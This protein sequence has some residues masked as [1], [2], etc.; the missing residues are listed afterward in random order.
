[1]EV[2]WCSRL[3][4][5]LAVWNPDGD[6][7]ERPLGPILVVSRRRS[8]MRC[9]AMQ[10]AIPVS[11]P[12]RTT[13]PAARSSPP[14]GWPTPLQSG[15]AHP[16]PLCPHPPIGPCVPWLPS[17]LSTSGG[18]LDPAVVGSVERR[19]R[20]QGLHMQ[21]TESTWAKSVLMQVLHLMLENHL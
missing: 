15:K 5:A 4:K 21:S 19:F 11:R 8:R 16:L 17:A 13:V 18:F 10:I 9:R 6:R 14:N 20:V 3:F 1:M 2:R 7:A 12:A